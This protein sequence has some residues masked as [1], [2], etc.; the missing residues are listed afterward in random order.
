MKVTAAATLILSASREM[1]STILELV[2]LSHIIKF[3][4]GAT[5]SLTPPIITLITAYVPGGG[6]HKH[7]LQLLGSYMNAF[8]LV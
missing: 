6:G 5:R 8:S 4:S 1:T 7:T 3:E 2:S